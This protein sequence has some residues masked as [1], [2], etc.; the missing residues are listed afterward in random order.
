VISA[1]GRVASGIRLRGSATA[2][3]RPHLAMPGVTSAGA[4]LRLP[5]AVDL[6][7]LAGAGPSNVQI[8]RRLGL[9]PG[10][11]AGTG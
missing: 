9:S 10:T 4:S 11:C 3:L 6:P 8:A 1:P 5:S 2:L 7:I